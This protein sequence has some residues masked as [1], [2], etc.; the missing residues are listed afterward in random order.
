M[1]KPWKLHRPPKIAEDIASEASSGTPPFDEAR[2]SLLEAQVGT[3]P[4]LDL[5]GMAKGEA[6]QEL[7]SFLN[8]EYRRGTTAVRVITGRGDQ[9]LFHMAKQV[10]QD[11]ATRHFVQAFENHPLPGQSNAV[12][13][14]ALVPRSR[15]RTRASP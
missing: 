6:K 10:L 5:H 13:L 4:E 15:A 8:R 11:Y 2:V 1:P 14:V 12:L 7:E 3:V 9:I